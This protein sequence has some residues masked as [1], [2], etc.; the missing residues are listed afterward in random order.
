MDINA[1]CYE[2]GF[3]V[4]S[5]IGYGFYFWQSNNGNEWR[6]P[7]AIQ[8]LWPLLLLLC[9][10]WIPESPRW[11]IMKG[12]LEE[13]KRIL[14]RL[15]SRSKNLDHSFALAELYQIQKQVDVDSRM[16]TSW[17]AMF[18]TPAT[19]KR[20]FLSMGTM[21]IIQCSGVLVINSR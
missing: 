17:L 13:A 4:A 9:L 18:R 14:I 6:P 3:M 5:W 16:D 8:C 11:L 12:R 2:F 19:R 15:H 21:A 1:I 10:P 7:L 20:C